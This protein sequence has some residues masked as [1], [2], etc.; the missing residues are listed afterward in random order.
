VYP[1]FNIAAA[2]GEHRKLN[3]EDSY[4]EMVVKG[5]KRAGLGH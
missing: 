1:D 5:L 2:V 3:F 4:I